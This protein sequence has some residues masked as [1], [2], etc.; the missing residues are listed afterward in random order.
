[1]AGRAESLFGTGLVQTRNI[2]K[3]SVPCRGTDGEWRN[4]AGAAVDLSPT[5]QVGA[6]TVGALGDQLARNESV[7]RTRA[8]VERVMLD[9]GEVVITA[10]R[11]QANVVRNQDVYTR[12]AQGTGLGSITIDG[13][14]EP[15]PNPGETVNLAG[16]ARVTPAVVERTPQGITVVGLRVELLGGGDAGET[17]DISKSHAHINPR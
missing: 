8:R 15:I 13:V 7:V 5:V 17:F 2:V 6:A 12:T 9:G 11:S 10:I 1:L 3:K 4:A 14:S 16:V